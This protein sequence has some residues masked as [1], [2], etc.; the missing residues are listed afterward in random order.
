[1]PAPVRTVHQ[2][3]NFQL[4]GPGTGIV[5]GAAIFLTLVGFAVVLWWRVRRFDPERW[6]PAPGTRERVWVGGY[7]KSDGTKVAGYY[8]CAPGMS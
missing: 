4:A 3:G 6:T 7:T 1:M 2:D 8:R 5:G